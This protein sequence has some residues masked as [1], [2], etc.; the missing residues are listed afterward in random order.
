[1]PK[2][3]SS[4]QIFVADGV[5]GMRQ[6]EDHRFDE[7]QWTTSVR[8]PPE[9][10][11]AWMAQLGT[12]TE[13]RGLNMSTFGQLEADENSG[14]ISF[15]P[16]TATGSDERIEIAWEKRRGGTLELRPRSKPSGERGVD[17]AAELIA[18]VSR[19][20]KEG[21]LS[22]LHQRGLLRYDGLPWRGELW[23]DDE[24]R[25]G[26]PSKY[27]DTLLGPQIVV[28]DAMVEGI[29]THGVAASFQTLLKEIRLFMAVVLGVTMET[30]QWGYDWISEIDPQLG[31]MTCKLGIVG[32]T[33]QSASEGFP[34]RGSL[35]KVEQ[36]EATRPGLG[37]FGIRSDMHE[38]WV[39]SDIE[40]LWSMFK[41]LPQKRREQFLSAANA[42][43]LAHR[44]GTEQRTARAAFLVVA[45][46]ALKPTSKKFQRANVYD[47]LASLA[48]LPAANRLK[49]QSVPPQKVRSQHLHRGEL[50]A[51]ELAPFIMHD[52]FGDPSFDDMLRDLGMLTRICLIEWLRCGGSY[53]FVW[54]QREN[55]NTL[56]DASL[57]S[58]GGN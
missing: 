28:I 5:G 21:R 52:Y 7:S 29:G 14:T 19:R 41:R 48:G 39:P 25:L 2:K 13:E 54:I 43:L 22:R 1:M 58:T 20:T 9:E 37:P 3:R 10:A 12:E 16:A 38:R 46:E 18:A 15:S 55:G 4:V 30:P 24:T 42:L 56:R 23:L 32:Y 27:P 6:V 50:L 36:R 47:V 57:S 31:A 44:M 33:E 51:G 34:M 45:C 35:R 40:I 49:E 53:N 26:P 11:S 17:S 8:V